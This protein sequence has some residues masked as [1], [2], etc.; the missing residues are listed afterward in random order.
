MDRLG[1]QLDTAQKTFMEVEGTRSR[2]LTRV[3]EQI[4]NRSQN[5]LPEGKKAKSAQLELED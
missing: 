5:S 3:V 2:Q 1:R 4:S